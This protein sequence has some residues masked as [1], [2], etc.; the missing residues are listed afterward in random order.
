MY[1]LISLTTDK[2]CLI[3]AWIACEDTPF[4]NDWGT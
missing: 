4:L 1:N 2:Q 3:S